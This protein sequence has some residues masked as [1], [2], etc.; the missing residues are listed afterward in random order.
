MLR[1]GT[2]AKLLELWIVAPVF[3]PQFWFLRNLILLV[4]ASP[5]IYF[6]VKRFGLG[7]L[8]PVGGLWLL[9]FC[10]GCRREIISLTGVLFFGLGASIALHK[11]EALAWDCLGRR[12]L[13]IS[14]LCYIAIGSYLYIY[15]TPAT[16][17][18]VEVYV[19]L[20]IP[21]IWFNYDCLRPIMESR[22]GTWLSQ[23]TFFIYAAHVPVIW[24]F[25][26][27]F[28]A[29]AHRGDGYQLL[30]FFAPPLVTI[31]VCVLMAVAMK[32]W[33]PALYFFLT[34]GR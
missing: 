2:W 33:V 5:L 21:A 6:V 1:S 22:P 20:G 28:S 23:F 25:A 34:G 32:R 31:A 11:P 19:V 9:G 15:R 14:W 29:G 4:F 13:G 10:P 24:I 8:L 7:V 18:F 27:A 12:L 17:V 16:D 30:Q 26:V 3:Q